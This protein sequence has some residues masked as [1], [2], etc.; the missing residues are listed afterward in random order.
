MKGQ[1]VVVA[2]RRRLYRCCNLEDQEL[3][4]FSLP[5]IFV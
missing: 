3:A 4:E 5:I 1:G 2:L